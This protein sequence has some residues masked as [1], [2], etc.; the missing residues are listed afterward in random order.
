MDLKNKIID[1]IKQKQVAHNMQFHKTWH[2]YV[3]DGGIKYTSVTN[4]TSQFTKPFNIDEIASSLAVSPSSNYY[5]LTKDEIIAQWD[6][7][8]RLGT[9]FH[10]KIEDYFDGR[11]GENF[12]YKDIFDNWGLTPDNVISEL[13]VFSTKL[14][15]AGTIDIIKIIERQNDVILEIYDIKTTKDIQFDYEKLKKASFQIT[16]YKLLLETMLKKFEYHKPI[17]VVAGSIISIE[18]NI[19]DVKEH[20]DIF[21]FNHFNAPILVDILKDST[22]YSILKEKILELKLEVENIVNEAKEYREKN[23]QRNSK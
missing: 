17:K 15:L 3:F 9:N 4:F 23:E 22:E 2:R 6:A 7:M 18:R 5:G 10:S 19:R 8:N 11:L 12:K 13:T 20:I 1:Y 21:D 14:R 16:L